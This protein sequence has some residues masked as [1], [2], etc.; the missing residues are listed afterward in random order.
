MVNMILYKTYEL[1]KNNKNLQFEKLEIND[2]RIGMLLTAVRLSDG[3][4]GVAS[5][6]SDYQIHCLKENRDYGDFTPSKIK[7]HK[8]IDLFETD[9]RSNIIDTLKIAALNAIS[10]KLMSASNYKLLVDTDPVDLIELDLQKT[11]TIVGGFHSYIRKISDTDNKLN[12]LE[13]NKDF[14]SDEHKKFFIPA[15]DFK[16]V[17]P[18]SDIIIITGL[19]LVNNTIDGLLASIPPQ[20]QVI[21][22]GP[23]SSIIPDALFSYGVSM[24][25]ATQITDPGMLFTIVEEAGAGYHLFKY[26]ARKICILNE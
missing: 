22:T 1:L 2:V 24:I 9:K 14:L 15:A 6:L 7:G 17:L 20:A 5:T 19:T 23:S 3:S 25:G 4:C 21:V 18:V 8:V 12:V 26:C 11:I 10:S 13:M 16:K